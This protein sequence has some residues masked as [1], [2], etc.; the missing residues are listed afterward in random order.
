MNIRLPYF[1]MLLEAIAQGNT[2]TIDAFGKH[3]HWGYWQD[4]RQADGTVADFAEAADRLSACVY[5]AGQIQD[6]QRVL[7]VGCGFGGTIRCLNDRYHNLQITGLNI[8]QRQID[9]AR[10]LA[11]PQHQNTIDFVCANACELPFLDQSFDVVLAV[12]CIFHFP[13]R[14]QFFKEAKRVLKPGGML[15]LSD[16]TLQPF[17]VPFFKFLSRFSNGAVERLYGDVGSTDFTVPAYHKLAQETGFAIATDR[18][19]TRNTLPTY[20]VL[21]RICRQF[22]SAEAE[23]V[24]ASQELV[25]QLGL[26]RYVVLSFQC[27]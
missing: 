15:A 4:P 14:Q 1:D 26:V 8:D 24:A 23:S 25:S 11:I 6:G 20:P 9:R 27:L 5:E 18:D 7:D 17:T 3:V 10:S 13:S 2:E 21:K 16:F 12:E 22:A 19:I